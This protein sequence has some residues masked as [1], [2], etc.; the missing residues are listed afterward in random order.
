[1]IFEKCLVDSNTNISG[2]M[3][4][5]VLSVNEINQFKPGQFIE[6][7]KEN[8]V[9]MFLPKPFSIYKIENKKLSI[10]YK[11]YGPGTLEM[12]TWKNTDQ[13]EIWG[14][15]GNSFTC[16]ND[17]H[18]ALIAGGIG[19]PPIVALAK[20]LNQKSSF[21]VFIGG[22]SKD[23][24]ICV[25]E[26]ESY[27]AKVHIATDDGSSGYH[28]LLPD[29]FLEH[30]DRFGY[31]Y[32]CG[33]KIMEEKISN[34]CVD[35]NIP[36]EVSMEEYMACGMGICVGCV[37]AVKNNDEIEYKRLCKNG[38]VLMADDIIWNK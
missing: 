16:G 34:I 36:C 7:Y 30:I 35:K 32:T 4:E 12:S 20:E 22:R 26:C 38:P 6:V 27:G 31:A 37:V 33:P 23:E 18:K 15:I 9:K 10:L 3:Y 8:C 17:G 13:C 29:L 19:I 2:S 14:P 5:L 24:I 25:E 21:E 11:I 28:G 1:M